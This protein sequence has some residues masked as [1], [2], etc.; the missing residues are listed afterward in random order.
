MQ[1][2]GLDDT[3]AGTKTAGRNVSNLRLRYADDTTIMAESK[4]EV[5]SLLRK[6]KEESEKATGKNLHSKNWG[7]GIQSHHFTANRW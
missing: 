3:E 7:P 2:T 5:K 1:N 6:V 4:E